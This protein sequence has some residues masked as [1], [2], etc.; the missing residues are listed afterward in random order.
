[1]SW[2]GNSII[3]IDFDASIRLMIHTLSIETIRLRQFMHKFPLLRG[4]RFESQSHRIARQEFTKHAFDLK[5]PSPIIDKEVECAKLITSL[6]IF[7]FMEGSSSID[8]EC[9]CKFSVSLRSCTKI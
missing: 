9:F 4:H 7:R 1:M 2:Q 3:A 5:T 8:I 6:D